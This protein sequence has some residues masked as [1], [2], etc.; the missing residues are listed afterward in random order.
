MC[1]NSILTRACNPVMCLR[2]KESEKKRPKN[3]LSTSAS[4][5]SLGRRRSG[6]DE[7]VAVNNLCTHLL[8]NPVGDGGLTMQ[9]LAGSLL[10]QTKTARSSLPNRH[11]LQRFHRSSDASDWYALDWGRTQRYPWSRSVQVCQVGVSVSGC[12]VNPRVRV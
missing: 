8:E 4:W 3:N 10:L 9:R 5:L 1:N 12:L 11:C 7:Q 6:K 2:F